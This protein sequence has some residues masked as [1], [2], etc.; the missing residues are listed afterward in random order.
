MLMTAAPSR[1][2]TSTSGMAYVGG[3]YASLKHQSKSAFVLERSSP[4]LDSDGG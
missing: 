3:G 1:R 2:M 4:N